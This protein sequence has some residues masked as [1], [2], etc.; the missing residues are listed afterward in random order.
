MEL[1]VAVVASRLQGQFVGIP[2]NQSVGYPK[3]LIIQLGRFTGVFA[4]GICESLF[5]WDQVVPSL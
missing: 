3:V 1:V 2:P 5:W 4:P